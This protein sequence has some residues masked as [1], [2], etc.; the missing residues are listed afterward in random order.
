MSG[1]EMLC[2]DYWMPVYAFLRRTGHGHENSEDLTQSFFS[3][4]F[5]SDWAQKADRNKGKFRNFLLK[6]LKNYLS[7]QR[8]KSNAQKR[9]GKFTIHSLDQLEE[10]LEKHVTT[11]DSDPAIIFDKVYAYKLIEK[12]NEILADEY[13]HK[14]Q[15]NLFLA[16]SEIGPRG[17]TCKDVAVEFN[18]DVRQV[19]KRNSK[20]NSRRKEIF[21]SL[22]RNSLASDKDTHDELLYLRRLLNH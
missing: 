2:S 5:T 10:C 8:R 6:S 16:L 12:T 4:L 18:L 17:R 11:S 14:G 15:L 3:H 9:G 1:W 20:L 22:V 21:H 7:N 13:Y 19:E